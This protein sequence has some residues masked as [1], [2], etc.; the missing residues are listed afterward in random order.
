VSATAEEVSELDPPDHQN[1]EIQPPA[2]R[3]FDQ[4]LEKPLSQDR[5]RPIDQGQVS[6]VMENSSVMAQVEFCSSVDRSR[7]GFAQKAEEQEALAEKPAP[8]YTGP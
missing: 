1:L 6:T 2:S 4:A 3:P 5:A 7:R 8:V